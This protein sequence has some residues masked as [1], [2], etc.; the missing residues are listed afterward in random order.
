MDH[1][2]LRL[3]QA[4][5][6]LEQEDSALDVRLRRLLRLDAGWCVASLLMPI[7]REHVR[8]DPHQPCAK[9]LAPPFESPNTRERL[10]KHLRGQVLGPVTIPD[11]ALDVRVDAMEVPLVQRPELRGIVL[12]RFDQRALVVCSWLQNRS[13][14]TSSAI[15]REKLRSKVETFGIARRPSIRGPTGRAACILS[16]ERR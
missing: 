15:R 13:S 2:K 9:R 4:V 8:R 12:S 14:S 11:T 1:S 10:A 6:Q 16:L 7:I 3:G 5:Y